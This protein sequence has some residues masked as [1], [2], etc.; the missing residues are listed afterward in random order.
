MVVPRRQHR[1]P[2][3][4]L[5]HNTGH[6]FLRNVDDITHMDRLNDCQHQAGNEVAERL[7]GRKTYKYRN[8]AGRAKQRRTCPLQRLHGI[9]N[10]NQRNHIED[11]LQ[12][13][14]QIAHRCCIHLFSS[15]C[16]CRPVEAAMN[17]FGKNLAEQ[18]NQTGS[19]QKQNESII[20]YRRSKIKDIFHLEPA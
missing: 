3:G 18:K 20:K 12:D 7:L 4:D 11:E 9:E 6:V 15:Q 19:H 2:E 8:D 16:F 1:M 14:F 10:R 17:D 13:L 5:L